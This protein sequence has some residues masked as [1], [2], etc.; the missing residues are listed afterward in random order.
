MIGIRCQLARLSIGLL[1]SLFAVI[2]V[3]SRT[4]F[5]DGYEEI[6]QQQMLNDLKR[7]SDAITLRLKELDR[8]ALDWS[9]WD[10]TYRFIVDRNQP[11]ITSNMP[12]K[13]VAGIDLHL[14]LFLDTKNEEIFSKWISLKTQQET[15]PPKALLASLGPLTSLLKNRPISEGVRGIVM[16][17]EGPLLVAA[18]P[19]ITSTFSG[20]V[21]GTF[22]VGRMLDNSIIDQIRQETRLDL[23]LIKGGGSLT[24]HRQ[25]QITLPDDQRIRGE[26]LLTD[27]LGTPVLTLQVVS[28]RSVYQLGQKSSMYVAFFLVASGTLIAVLLFVYGEKGIVRHLIRM[29]RQADEIA[30]TGDSHQRLV[31]G[32]A[33]ELKQLGNAVN[34]M[35]ASLEQAHK[36]MQ[37]S[38]QKHRIV[39]QQSNDAII[40]FDP[41]LAR[42]VDANQAFYRITGYQEDELPLLTPTRLLVT[43][44][45]LPA[46]LR[47]V[48]HE[49]NLHLNGL[50]C[51]DKDGTILEMD[52]AVSLL[53]IAGRE[54]LSAILRDMTQRNVEQR[55]VR[56]M[57]ITDA[58]TGIPNRR[59][60][61]ERGEQELERLKRM[62]KHQPDGFTLGCIMLDIDYF[63][64]INDNHGHQCGDA[65]LME[66]ARRMNSSIRPYDIIGRYGGEEF[67]V[68]LTDATGDQTILVAERIW[69]NIRSVPF[70]H[71]AFS[72]PVTASLGLSWCTSDDETLDDI[73]KRA[74][75]AMY[76]AKDDGRDKIS[77]AT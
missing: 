39:L 10:D 73:L 49:R 72:F 58:L 41:S 67:T 29:S 53:T 66:L 60:L 56:N 5:L 55:M 2:I 74:D 76:C 4:V 46:L 42:I 59:H 32:G 8:T 75:A 6:E 63:K 15:I 16:L 50:L 70:Y 54:I 38:E 26:Q 31:I 13:A 23:Q 25:L 52:V 35:L 65:V 57:A 18:R 69:Q 37:E 71:G 27:I 28:P 51:R 24:L 3:L 47:M 17:P 45:R 12:D 77:L 33:Q 14:I 19:I 68:F 30:K 11:Y 43:S 40:L 61:L 9:A 20:P 36:E 48:R 44:N 1:L 64:S 22:V 7:G 34:N 62:R 21:R